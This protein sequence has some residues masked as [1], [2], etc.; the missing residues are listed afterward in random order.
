MPLDPQS[1]YNCKKGTITKR[2]DFGIK[3]FP[4][5]IRNFTEVKTLSVQRLARPFAKDKKSLLLYMCG[6]KSTQIFR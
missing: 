4:E 2:H 5:P 1:V 6:N 3:P